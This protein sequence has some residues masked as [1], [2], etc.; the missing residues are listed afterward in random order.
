MTLQ[1]RVESMGDG[2]LR[3]WRDPD[4][5]A[6]ALLDALRRC[7]GVIDAIVTEQHALVT[8]DPSH[9]PHEPW[10]IEDRVARADAAVEAR[11]HVIRTTYDGVDLD[12]VASRAGLAREEV[13][14]LHAGGRYT[15]RTI[16]FLPGFA[17]LGPVSPPLAL[18]RRATPRARVEAG[19]VGLAAGYTGVYP[20]A[21]PGGWH[22]IGHAIDFAPFDVARGATLALG[23]RV[24]FEAVAR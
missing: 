22:I 16:G 15:V 20:V 21:S 9:V 12:D 23:D 7:P 14:R 4:R 5:D 13:V 3:W 24:R 6:R 17:Y 1:R 8:F 19:A 2:A 18:A 11:E 10:A